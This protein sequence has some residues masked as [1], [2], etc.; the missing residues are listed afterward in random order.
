MKMASED[1]D[2]LRRN[3]DVLRLR[4]IAENLDEHSREAKRLKLGHVGFMVRATDAEVLARTEKGARQRIARACFEELVTLDG[5]EFERQPTIDRRQIMDLAELGFLDRCEAALFLGPSGV[6]KSHLA[7]ALGVRACESGYRVEYHRAPELL[8]I[9]HIALAD[10]SLDELL[11]A[12]TKPQLLIV[13][14]L[15]AG[16]RKSDQDFGALF[17]E[18]V[19]ARHRRGA[20]IIVSNFAVTDWAKKLGN[21]PL[22]TAAVDRLLDGAHVI[23]IPSDAASYRASRKR[24]AGRLPRRR[25]PASVRRYRY[26]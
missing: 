10:D 21:A 18:L 5:F 22:V 26:K 11:E 17:Y 15:G 20:L 2:R 13:D 14:E 25:L 6:G 1:L 23:D 12:L 24:G 19:G 7:T 3:L 8:P 16:T 9:L 4:N